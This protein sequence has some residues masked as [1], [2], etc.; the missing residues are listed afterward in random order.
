MKI[1]TLR[2]ELFVS[3]PPP[4]SPK[5]DGSSHSFAQSRSLTERTQLSDHDRALGIT[6]GQFESRPAE[7]QLLPSRGQELPSGEEGTATTAECYA[8]EASSRPRAWRRIFP[9]AS[10]SNG[11]CRKNAFGSNTPCAEVMAPG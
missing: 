1:Y 9:S 2:R 7:V 5:T 6:S 8:D 10:I 11:F 3:H 4:A